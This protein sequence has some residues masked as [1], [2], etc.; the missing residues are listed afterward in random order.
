MPL[1]VDRRIIDLV[2][3]VL[4][5][6]GHVGPNENVV[7]VGAVDAHQLANDRHRQ[8]GCD[9]D[10]EVAFAAGCDAVD[11]PG[12]NLADSRFH[13]AHGAGQELSAE[14]FALFEMERIVGHDQHQARAALNR[15]DGFKIGT[16][17]CND[18][19]ER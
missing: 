4:R 5:S 2:F 3:G 9:I 18:T 6:Q 7:P 16:A 17:F 13:P 15:R 11:E 19:V 8:A 14:G 1:G 12:N 10:D